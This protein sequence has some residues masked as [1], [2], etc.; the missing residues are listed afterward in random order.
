MYAN[1]YTSSEHH[2]IDHSPLSVRIQAGGSLCSGLAHHVLSNHRYTI[3][4]QTTA[5]RAS[6]YPYAMAGHTSARSAFDRW[7]SGAAHAHGAGA[8]R[9]GAGGVWWRRGLWAWRGGAGCCCTIV[10]QL[11]ISTTSLCTRVGSTALIVAI[12]T[13]T[14]GNHF[15][16]QSNG[17]IDNLGQ[18]FM[19]RY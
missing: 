18:M 17:S 16:C 6:I 13:V 2:F 12:R 15:A 11:F 4:G 1:L 7:S 3:Y 14:V 9:G 10:L 5:A 8:G 19:Y